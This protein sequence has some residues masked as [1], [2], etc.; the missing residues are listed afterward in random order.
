[1]L[2]TEVKSQVSPTTWSEASDRIEDIVGAELFNPRRKYL[3][4]VS[5]SSSLLRTLIHDRHNARREKEEAFQLLHGAF[6]TDAKRG[7]LLV[8]SS[9]ALMYGM[10]ITFEQ[11]LLDSYSRVLD[12]IYKRHVK[13]FYEGSI[14]E[15]KAHPDIFKALKALDFMDEHAFWSNY[16]LWRALNIEVRASNIWFPLPPCRHCIPFQNAYW[17][18]LKGPSDTT[19]KLLDN[20][21]EHLGVRTPRTVATARL[22]SVGSVAFH[23]SL[24]ILSAKASKEYASLQHFRHAANE[25]YSVG[26]SLVMLIEMLAKDY[27]L[28]NTARSEADMFQV[29]FWPATMIPPNVSPIRRSTRQHADQ[30]GKVEWGFAVK[31]GIT[32]CKGRTLNLSHK[33]REKQCDGRVLVSLIPDPTTDKVRDVR[34]K[35]RLCGTKTSFYCT[36]CKNYLCFGPSQ[37]F[38][39]SKADRI[40]LILERDTDGLISERPPKTLAMKEFDPLKEEW[41]SALFAANCCYLLQ[42]QEAFDRLWELKKSAT[43]DED[44]SDED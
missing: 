39:T 31:Q 40:K 34:S 23:R 30:P 8:G 32:P 2:P 20:V 11:D 25:R 37:S 21:E 1:M 14:E 38:A 18:V 13:I 4:P 36:G 10:D 42:H 35:C 12:Y 7:L 9:N 29:S 3:I 43:Y 17:N 22:L 5:S 16:M 44:G 6:V 24:Q 33:I 26:R 15:I 41:K 27:R 28:L 19:T